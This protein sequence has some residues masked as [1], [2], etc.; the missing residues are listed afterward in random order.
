LLGDRR[1]EEEEDDEEGEVFEFIDSSSL[2]SSKFVN[3]EVYE[4][5][6]QNESLSL[7]EKS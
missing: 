2:L 3:D 7:D 1:T 5:E 4:D 6:V